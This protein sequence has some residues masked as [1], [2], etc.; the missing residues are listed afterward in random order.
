MNRESMAG[1]AEEGQVG[2]DATPNH[3]ECSAV[4]KSLLGRKGW[5]GASEVAVVIENP[6]ANARDLRVADSIPGSGRSPGGGHG[7]SLQYS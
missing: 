1:P 3:Q 5:G 4:S 7:S 2:R 6:P